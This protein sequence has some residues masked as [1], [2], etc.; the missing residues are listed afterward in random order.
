M[1]QRRICDAFC[2]QDWFTVAVEATAPDAPWLLS[3]PRAGRRRRRL[4]SC[5]LS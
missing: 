1:I 4:R 2:K 3:L 5:R